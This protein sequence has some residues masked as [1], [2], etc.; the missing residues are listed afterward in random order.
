LTSGILP[1]H[2]LELVF[3][4]DDIIASPTLVLSAH[5]LVRFWSAGTRKAALMQVGTIEPTVEPIQVMRG[6]SGPFAGVRLGDAISY[7]FAL[8]PSLQPRPGTTRLQRVYALLDLGVQLSNPPPGTG[9]TRPAGTSTSSR[10]RLRRERWPLVQHLVA[11]QDHRGPG[12]NRSVSE[13]QPPRR[14]P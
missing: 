1:S 8:D 14:L 5:S 3:E 10:P 11:E 12:D 4:Q 13:K 7:E 9:T 2:L 6:E